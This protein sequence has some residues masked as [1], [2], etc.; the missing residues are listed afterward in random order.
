LKALLAQGVP[1]YDIRRPQGW[2]QAD[3]AKPNPPMGTG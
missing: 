2:R 3:T 1:L